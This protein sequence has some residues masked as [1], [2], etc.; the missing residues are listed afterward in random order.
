MISVPSG[1]PC[2]VGAEW[3][4]MSSAAFHCPVDF[5]LKLQKTFAVPM[6]LT[7]TGMPLLLVQFPQ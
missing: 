2:V 7:W 3:N 4:Q 5:G 1:C 6:L